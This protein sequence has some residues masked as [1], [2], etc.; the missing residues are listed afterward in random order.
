MPWQ[1]VILHTRADQA[2]NAADALH[3]LGA[4]SVTFTDDAD[5]PIYEPELGTTPLWPTTQVIGLFAEQT[6]IQAMMTQL[7]HALPPDALRAWESQYLEDQAWERA[8]MDH[9]HP[10]RFGKRLWVCPSEQQPPEPE[11]VN[12]LLDP[13]LAF[14]TGTHP[15][16]ALCLEWLDAHLT[17]GADVLDFGCGSGILA[18]AAARLGANAVWAVDIDP[19]ALLATN[20]NANKNKVLEKIHI[21]LAENLPEMQYDIVLANILAGPLQ[22]LAEQLANA[23]KPGGQIVLSGLLENQM[24][25][26]IETY[27]TWFNMDD[28]AL[29][30]SWGRLAGTRK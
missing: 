29:K 13:G 27:T 7:I 9:F 1:Q 20:D 16:T 19:Q 28:F 21:S 15:T 12:I 5:S 17:P 26:L 23:V 22:S 4:V 30:E 18:V 2:E 25:D 11:A 24:Q 6:D 10:M 8:W 3:D 14:G